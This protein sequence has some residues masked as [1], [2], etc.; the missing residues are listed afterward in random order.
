MAFDLKKTQTNPLLAPP[1]VS[2]PAP[3]REAK[4]ASGG[5]SFS[6]EL[7][8][9]ALKDASAKEVP[10]KAAPAKA[11]GK[12]PL[13][14]DGKE[15]GKDVGKADGP[16]AAKG[17]GKDP[18]KP[19]LAQPL[20]QAALANRRE[21]EETPVVAFLTGHLERLVPGDIPELVTGN[22]F[23]TTAMAQPDLQAFLTTGMELGDLVSDLELPDALIDEA[24]SLGIDLKANITANELFKAIGVD[25]QR[26]SAEL[27]LLKDNLATNG[28]APYLARAA[29]LRASA[30]LPGKV[31]IDDPRAA[32]PSKKAGAPLEAMTPG[33]PQPI[34]LPV[35]PTPELANAVAM[36]TPQTPQTLQAPQTPQAQQMGASVTMPRVKADGPSANPRSA[37]S[38]ISADSLPQ[39]FLAAQPASVATPAVAAMPRAPQ[40]HAASFDAFAQMGERLAASDIELVTIAP[41]APTSPKDVAAAAK[42]E[43][44]AWIEAALRSEGAASPQDVMAQFAGMGN[45]TTEAISVT[46]AP[47]GMANG[48]ATGASNSALT[49]LAMTNVPMKNVPMTNVPM[50][51][52]PMT[53]VAAGNVPTPALVDALA[54]LRGD[55]PERATSDSLSMLPSVAA[56]QAP[57]A[58]GARM[59][60]EELRLAAPLAMIEGRGERSGARDGGGFGNQDERKEQGFGEAASGVA[61]EHVSLQSLHK[62][63]ASE[64]FTLDAP[65]ADPILMSPQE[66]ADMMQKIVERATY[67]AKDGGGV[68]RLDVGNAEIGRMELA[69]KMV[70]GDRVDL[71][72]L[73]SSDRAR[74]M[75]TDGLSKL[76]DALSAQHVQ[77][78]KVE[79]GVGGKQPQHEPHGGFSGFAGGFQQNQNHQQQ[80][81]QRFG[82][83]PP[84]VKSTAALRDVIAPSLAASRL[85]VAPGRIQ[86]RA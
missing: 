86:V 79:V 6:E 40:F 35:M 15:P 84:V 48:A 76:R 50:T 83:A 49:N 56:P 54:S 68:V 45:P 11:D 14:A 80:Q 46:S 30:E 66:R 55:R 5:K 44:N 24:E 31:Q 67:L 62:M 74:E 32:S 57:T 12:E 73:A 81:R 41:Q 64:R 20:R 25:P 39:D 28:I 72:I 43:M 27:K 16:D 7:E 65:K 2:T 3:R 9:P 63:D 38:M 60:I 69:V 29:A 61:P 10:T 26:V 36:S 34:Q 19:G 17:E 70:D 4:A 8:G 47:I 53:N 78:G 75:M 13:K 21:L 71:K 18:Q 1:P 82:E 33:L 58:A 51:N 77:L 42:P 37:R 59:P 23:L 52:V 22:D 85:S